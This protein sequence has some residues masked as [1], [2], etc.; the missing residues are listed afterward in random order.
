MWS[1][2]TRNRSPE[3]AASGYSM[4]HPG[5]GTSGFCSATRQQ[6]HVQS[7]G[8]GLAHRAGSQ[9]AAPSAAVPET[10]NR[11]HEGPTGTVHLCVRALQIRAESQT[12]V[13]Q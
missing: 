13:K 11:P 6:Q 8:K 12:E 2:S 10:T 3:T 4:R 5:S 9:R 1:E 7:S